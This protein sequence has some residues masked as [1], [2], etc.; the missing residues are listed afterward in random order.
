MKR[1]LNNLEKISRISPM[2][3]GLLF[4]IIIILRNIILLV[5]FSYTF[6]PDSNIY[7][8]LGKDFFRTLYIS[9]LV[10]FPYPLL[11]AV[12]NTF[13][14]PYFLLSLQALIT[15]AAGGF[16]VYILGKRSRLLAVLIGVLFSFDLVWGALSRSLMTDS[17][18]AALILI[19]L[20]LL[21]DHF[22]RRQPIGLGEMFISGLVYGLTLLF[23]PSNIYFA[24]LLVPL[25][26]FLVRS[27][28][29]LILLFSGGALIF[30]AAGLINLRG[31]GSFYFISSHDSYTST[32]TAFP[33]FVYK[34]FSPDNGPKSL[35]LN[36]YLSNCYPGVDFLTRVDRSE[37]GAFDS[38]NNMNLIL[39]E[40]V[41]C[42]TKAIKDPAIAQTIIP[43]AY[44]ESILH[45]P[46]KFALIMYQENAV[47]FRYNDPYILRWYLDAGKNYGCESI[48]WCSEIGVSHL[49]WDYQTWYSSLYEKIDTKIIQVYLAPV[50]LISAFY[51]DKNILPYN[52]VWFGMI[53]LLILITRGRERFLAIA[54]FVT[55]QFTC[56]TVI[57]GLGFTERY[58]A[59]LAPLQ[60]V[61]SGLLFTV[62][63]RKA[64]Q[65]FILHQP[66]RKSKSEALIQPD[67]K[68]DI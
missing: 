23:R 55:L 27:W 57:A 3:I 52:I 50:G 44:I 62:I 15:A 33:L 45:N 30:L 13:N 1:I 37:G 67:L 4:G 31:T 36:Q 2:I 65:I 22:D 10:T 38:I 35:E 49:V 43:Q 58:A 59:M 26:I 42:I 7:I 21:L 19:C 24:V 11:N 68:M 66:V 18:F 28:K 12:T 48:P 17:I 34:L 47:F 40:I 32:Y 25:Y 5:L 20:G 29:K 53:V 61:L 46:I 16:F 60:I 9:P 54:T 51:S 8:H 63:I 41:P 39:G 64:Y 56:I 6:L 14:S